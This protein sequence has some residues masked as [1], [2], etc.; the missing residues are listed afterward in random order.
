MPKENL[1]EYGA[2]KYAIK[3]IMSNR[4]KAAEL[5]LKEKILEV[6]GVHEK[7]LSEWINIPANDKREIPS[8][9]LY[10]IAELLLVPMEELFNKVK[11]AA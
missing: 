7:T 2:L 9:Q 11:H 6:T 8:G 1:T 5:K 4:T 10:K 3:Q